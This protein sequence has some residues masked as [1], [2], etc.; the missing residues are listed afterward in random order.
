MLSLGLR[1][2][3]NVAS[4]LAIVSFTHPQLVVTVVRWWLPPAVRDL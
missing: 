4:R 2:M 1:R 3:V